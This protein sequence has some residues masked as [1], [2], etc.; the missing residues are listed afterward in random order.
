MQSDAYVGSRASAATNT[1]SSPA[2][3]LD[4]LWNICPASSI[5]PCRVYRSPW[6]LMRSTTS[7]PSSFYKRSLSTP[8]EHFEYPKVKLTVHNSPAALSS[9]VPTSSSFLNLKSNSASRVPTLAPML[10]LLIVSLTNPATFK[11]YSASLTDP[12]AA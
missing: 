9:L 7:G 2:I 5:I 4:V 10:P 11:K 12:L 8:V 6:T 3:S 1:E